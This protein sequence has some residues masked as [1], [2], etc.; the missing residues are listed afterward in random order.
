MKQKAVSGIILTLLLMGMLTSAFNLA[1][2]GALSASSEPPATEWNRT[3]G[4]A[5]S[6]RAWSMVQTFDGGYAVAGWTQSFG[7]GLDDFWLVKTDSAGNMQWNRTYGGANPDEA[8]SVVQTD[9]GGYAVAGYT[10]SFGAGSWDFWLIKLALPEKPPKF[11]TLPFKDP[12]IVVGCIFDPE[13]GHYGIDFIK[14]IDIS[15]VFTWQSFD[16]VAAADGEAFWAEEKDSEGNYK[17]W[18]KYV[19]IKHYEKD[20]E[21]R[22]HY[23]LYA[24]LESV[25][26]KIPK[27]GDGT[28]T[29]QQGELIGIAGASGVADSSWIHLHFEVHKGDARSKDKVSNRVDPYDLNQDRDSRYGEKATS[30]KCGPNYLWTTDPPSLPSI[31]KLVITSPLEITPFKDLYYVGDALTANFTINN[32]GTES[33]ILNVLVVGG[34]DPAGEVVDFDKTYDITLNPSDSYDYQGS[35]TLPDKLGNYHFF[36]AYQTPD[37]NWKTNIDVEIDGKIIEDFNE[38]RRHREREIIAFEKTYVGPAQPPA[39]WENVSG[40][41]DEWTIGLGNWKESPQ[42]AVNQNNPEEIY[43]Q[44]VRRSDNWWEAEGGKLYKSTDGG[45]SWISINEGLPRTS[46]EYYWPIRAIALAPSNPNIV[47]VGTSNFDPYSGLTSSGVGIHKSTNGGLEWTSVGGPH[48]IEWWIFKSHYSISSMIVHPTNPDIVYT[49]TVGGGIWRTTNGGESWER[50]WELPARSLDVNTLAINSA[51]PNI[52]YAAAYNF[53]PLSAVLIPNCLIKS[54]DGGNTWE[55]LLSYWKKID[56]IAV[57]NRNA[58]IVYV[59]TEYFEV[60][61]SIDRGKNWDDA[62][63]TAGADPLPSPQYLGPTLGRSNSIVLHP[64]FSDVIYAARMWEFR[65]VYFSPN[66]GENWYSFGLEDNHVQELV[67]ASSANSRVL[68]AAASDGLF[69]I[70]LSE[71][72]IV[73]RLCSPG[74]LRVYDSQGKVTGLVNGEVREEI[75]NS[76]YNEENRIVTMIFPTDSYRYEV[77]GTDQGTYGLAVISI[78]EEA[79]TFT[80]IDIPTSANA[81]HQ[82]TV[83]WDALS[84]GEEGVTAKVDS[85]GD[86]M[87]EHIFT[88]DSELSYS[89]YVAAINAIN[90]WL[91]DSD[92]NEIESFRVVLTPYGDTELYKLTA[93]NPGQFYFNIL[94]NNTWPETLNL[95]IVY[96]LD[97]DFV[98]KGVKPI[99]VYT[100]LE[101]TVD[102]TDNCTFSDN[103]ITVYN[104]APNT[105]IYIT[106]HLDYALKGTTWT[107]EEVEAWYSEHSFSTTVRSITHK[108]VIT[109]PELQIPPIPLSLIFL[110]GVL[111]AIILCL[112]I[113]ITLLKYLLL[114]TK[115]QK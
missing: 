21:G 20:T 32:R 10:S 107:A 61:R 63:G 35:L 113:L 53:D 90:T 1:I 115:R 84:M 82:Y 9:D 68:Y 51:N 98:L 30:I 54:E 44:V 92:F 57:D 86:G 79:A 27:E 64:D 36:C 114:P 48:T 18:G 34:R 78:T 5:S 89:E 105:I 2:V 65:G 96:L 13:K 77:A 91:T 50:I 33:V 26:L 71:G 19:Y 52:I 22:N 99:H 4:G 60:Y 74:E 37:G 111:P 73:T 102:V 67:F 106:I 72:M 69:K 12:D 8:R 45:D 43:V 38:A 55:T 109:D 11:L 88:S 41:W 108:I 28:H 56:D 103:T 75:P 101:R 46:S 95:T 17:G 23:T 40:P 97:A 104:V 14:C 58:D 59:I 70:D 80:A 83:D 76:A 47:Y 25:D 87:F 16:V 24:H 39:L 6:D 112:G 7:A 49:G 62:S 3:Y 110:I 15:D 94:V 66:S 93:T 29:I 100:D 85:D 81:I 42:I 31:V